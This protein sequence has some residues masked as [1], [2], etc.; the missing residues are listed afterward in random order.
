MF[1]FN[2]QHPTEEEFLNIIITL[3]NWVSCHE[4]QFMT[5]YTMIDSW[6]LQKSSTNKLIEKL[7]LKTGYQAGK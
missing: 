6:R 2:S 3:C 5:E 4:S 7:E 1:F